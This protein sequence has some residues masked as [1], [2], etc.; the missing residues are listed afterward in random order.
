[1]KYWIFSIFLFSFTLGFSQK[2]LFGKYNKNGSSD[3]LYLISDSTYHVFT[4]RCFY[5]NTT[6]RGYWTVKGDSLYTYKY[7][8]NPISLESDSVKI[9]TDTLWINRKNDELWFIIANQNNANTIFKLSKN[10]NLIYLKA[11]IHG[12]NREYKKDVL[13][14]IEIEDYEKQAINYEV[15]SCQIKL[16]RD[17]KVIYKTK[18]KGNKFPENLLEKW[19]SFRTK[20]I[21]EISKFKIN[22]NGKILNN[23]DIETAKYPI[24]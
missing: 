24:K 20:D 15:K 16:L 21:I 1:M 5:D 23:Y 13:D 14:F 3:A 6:N 17:E 11:T 18:M 2:S 4:F 8:T 10:P 9:Y 12:F 22:V 19:P 7:Q